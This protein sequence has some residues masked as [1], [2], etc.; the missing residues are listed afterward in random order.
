MHAPTITFPPKINRLAIKALLCCLSVAV[1]VMNAIQVSGTFL[2]ML[3]QSHVMSKVKRN[4]GSA[5]L[6]DQQ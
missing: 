4:G 1:S 2:I 3:D 6:T 5:R